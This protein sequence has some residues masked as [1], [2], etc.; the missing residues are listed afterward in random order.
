M[1]LISLIFYRVDVDSS[2]ESDVDDDLDQP[3]I[4]KSKHHDLMMKSEG[5]RKGSFFKQAKKSYPMFPTHEERIKWDEYGEIIRCVTQS[6]YWRDSENICSCV[7][8][9]AAKKSAGFH[10]LEDFLV[11]ELQATEEEKSKFDSGLTNGDEPMDQ[12]LSVLPTK[13]ISNVES[14]EIRS[15]K[16]ESETQKLLSVLL[17]VVCG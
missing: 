7:Y 9:V 13:C 4:V 5:S 17:H 12:D 15:V 11:P 2:D 10:R 16:W 6:S 8:V 14:L 3:T 1:K